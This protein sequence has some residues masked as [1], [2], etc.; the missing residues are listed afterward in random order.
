MRRPLGVPAAL[1]VLASLVTGSAAAAENAADP[2]VD[3]VV[4]PSRLDIR[5]EPGDSIQVPIE[6]WN[7]GGTALE[8]DAYV[9]D[10]GIPQSDLIDVDA[11]AFT[12]SRWVSLKGTAVG[13]EAT[14]RTEMLLQID[15]PEDTPSGGY[16]A[17]AFLQSRPIEGDDGILPA[18]RIGV[19]LLIEVT[20]AGETIGRSA[21]VSGTDIGV[22]WNGFFDPE[23]VVAVTVDNTGN[24]HL[25]TGGVHTYRSWPGASSLETKVG[26][27]T[28]LR[29]TRHVFETSWDSVP[30]F[31]KVTV[32]SELVYQVGPDDV[33][34]ILTQHTVWIIPWHLIGI[35][36]LA[37]SLVFLYGRWRRSRT[38][39]L[40]WKENELT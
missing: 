2:V 30:I 1:L 7:R 18:G 13:L 9:D 17:F 36:L 35:L 23:V 40:P 6:V 14:E 37:A 16:H 34:V 28:A 10:I 15:V 38:A 33:P 24:A 22:R 5:A 32:T 11:L 8:L 29:G 26:P 4:S 19:T 12:A 3:F 25:V 21:Q 20:S 27:H 31:G 39:P